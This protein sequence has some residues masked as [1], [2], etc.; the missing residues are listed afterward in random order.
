MNSH[1]IVQQVYVLFFNGSLIASQPE[2]E[3]KFRKI[4]IKIMFMIN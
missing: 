2:Q 3:T 4:T 1:K